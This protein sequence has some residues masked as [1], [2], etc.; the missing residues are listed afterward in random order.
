MFC[1]A[2]FFL[3]FTFFLY[4][5]KL[6]FKIYILKNLILCIIFYFRFFL[7]IWGGRGLGKEGG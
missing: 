5:F 3:K 7:M 4:L 2:I 1:C 6:F